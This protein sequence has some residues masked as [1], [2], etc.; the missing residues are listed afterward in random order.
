MAYI[1][2]DMYILDRH[3]KKGVITN[4]DVISRCT[5]KIVGWHEALNSEI[6]PS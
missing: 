2:T 6:L 5:T 1:K 4:F 3:I